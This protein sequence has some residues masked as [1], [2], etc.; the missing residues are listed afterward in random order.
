MVLLTAPAA[1]AEG[2]FSPSGTISCE[3]SYQRGDGIR[4]AAYCT[5]TDHVT[6]H[7]ATL[8]ADGA[9]QSCANPAA[10]TDSSCQ[11]DPPL[12]QPTLAPGQTV[13]EG[14]FRCRAQADGITCTAAPSG[15]GFTITG[16]GVTPV[17]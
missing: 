14:P 11:S 4:D 8:S 1:G 10:A 3:I 16:G 15:R 12:E 13:V 17:G 2:F 9:L 5:F 6:A 7:S